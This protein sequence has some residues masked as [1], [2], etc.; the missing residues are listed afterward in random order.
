MCDPFRGKSGGGDGGSKNT[1]IRLKSS[2][3]CLTEQCVCLSLCIIAP[4]LSHTHTQPD[5]PGTKK[6]HSLE[7]TLHPNSIFGRVCCGCSTYRKKKK[8]SPLELAS[9]SSR[10]PNCNC[11]CN[12]NCTH[13]AFADPPTLT[14]QMR[15]KPRLLPEAR[16]ESKRPIEARFSS[17]RHPTC[18][19]FGALGSLDKH[20]ST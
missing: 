11:N 2:R 3:V 13:C 18:V 12:C 15:G 9:P 17:A 14:A 7:P 5:V 20:L 8:K 6:K 10:N 19:P 1:L 4:S 16:R